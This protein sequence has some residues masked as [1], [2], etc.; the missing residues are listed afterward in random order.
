[1]Q[2]GPVALLLRPVGDDPRQRRPFQPLGDDHR[3][4][5]AQDV[6]DHDVR[7]A[8]EGLREGPLRR[9]LLLVVQ[10]LLDPLGELGEQRLEVHAGDPRGHHPGQPRGVRQVGHERLVRPWVLDLHRDRPA[11]LPDGP[12]HLADARRRGGLVVERLE[13]APPLLAEVVDQHGVHLLGGQC[14]GLLL[15]LRQGRAVRRCHVLGQGRLEDA[16]RLADLHRPALELPEDAEHL[17][18]G[19]RLEL[20]RD[21][22]GRGAPDPLA[23]S[24]GCPAGVPD[25]QGRHLGAAGQ[26]AHR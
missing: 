5:G 24:E 20:G 11:V 13:L 26:G 12:V 1:M 17:L 25:R 9:G 2:P 18:G 7:V 21:G 10:L 14:G 6:G 8:A 4:P 22:F 3:V 23:D 15:Q 16:H 19:A